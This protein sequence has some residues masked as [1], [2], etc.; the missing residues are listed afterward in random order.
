MIR[1]IVFNLIIV[2]ILVMI[3]VAIIRANKP[4]PGITKA[5]LNSLEEREGLNPREAKYYKVIEE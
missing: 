4:A 3:A 1:K 2:L 5:N